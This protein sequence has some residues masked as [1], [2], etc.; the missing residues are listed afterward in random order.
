MTDKY[1]SSSYFDYKFIAK[2]V[3]QAVIPVDL[4]SIKR[5]G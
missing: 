3:S 4:E 1:S 2:N 5:L